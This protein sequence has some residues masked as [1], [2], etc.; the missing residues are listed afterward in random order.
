MRFLK[1]TIALVGIGFALGV[2]ACT[3]YVVP[4]EETGESP[5]SLADAGE[6]TAAEDD[7]EDDD[8]PPER[9]V[10]RRGD[11]EA[12]DS[13]AA[14]AEREARSREEAERQARMDAERR[15]REAAEREAQLRAEREAAKREAR[16]AVEREAAE[17]EARLAAE[18]E[19]AERERR[20]AA[21]R[22]ARLAAERE[23]AERAA[24]LAAERE[25]AERE[26]RLAA[27]RE[28]A[29][30]EAAE[31]EE[32][33]RQGRLAAERSGREARERARA[34]SRELHV[35]PGHHP[36]EGR[37]R[38]WH[39]DGPPG[40][41]PDAAPCEELLDHDLEGDVFILYGGESW[42]GSHDWEAVDLEYPGVVPRPVLALSRV[43][44]G[45]EAS[46]EEQELA[47]PADATG[48]QGSPASSG[49]PEDRADR[50]RS[51]PPG[52]PR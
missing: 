19:A 13:A 6:A 52:G 43:V 30:R 29:E 44:G 32:E 51:S 5:E 47:T 40:R 18:R 33:A 11:G 27:E 23:A 28:A 22:E 35:P 48:R 34:G 10:R 36:P 20:R 42:D 21:E 26:A 16:R 31:R 15:A 3:V 14:V 4:A 25:A 17:R 1:T 12:R 37:C 38:I 41:Q 24:R 7:A 50:G 2:G 45:D 49:P 8:Q 39:E 9:N 46:G